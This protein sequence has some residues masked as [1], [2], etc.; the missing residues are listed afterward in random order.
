M[1][2]EILNFFENFE[3]TRKHKGNMYTLNDVIRLPYDGG[4]TFLFLEGIMKT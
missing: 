2:L 3:D 1:Q 4:L